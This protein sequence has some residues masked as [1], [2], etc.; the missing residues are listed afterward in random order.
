M[1]CASWEWVLEEYT[2]TGRPLLA[3]PPAPPAPLPPLPPAPT[4]PG[5]A[6]GCLGPFAVSTICNAGWRWASAGSG[7]TP[8]SRS[9]AT[10]AAVAD[11]VRA[12]AAV[13]VLVVAPKAPGR[14]VG[15]SGRSPC[16]PKE[17]RVDDGVVDER[18]GS[19][20][21]RNQGNVIDDE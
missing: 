2:T 15:R 19:E 20:R 14:V 4:P 13:W 17:H 12:L 1:T 6:V 8:S 10:W 18:L 21:L 11:V 3:P 5:G 16:G 9:A 7:F